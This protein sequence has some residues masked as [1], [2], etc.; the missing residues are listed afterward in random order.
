MLLAYRAILAEPRTKAASTEDYS[1]GAARNDYM[2]GADV[3]NQYTHPMGE[4]IFLFP[5]SKTVTHIHMFG[6]V[7]QQRPLLCY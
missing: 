1:A 5:E 4:R 7:M 6:N 2:G 3:M